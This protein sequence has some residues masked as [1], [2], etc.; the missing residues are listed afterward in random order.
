MKELTKI[1]VCL[2]LTEMD[3]K[4]ISY[5]FFLAQTY[6]TLQKIYFVHNIKFDFPE[7]AQDI[8][9]NLEQPLGEIISDDIL[10]KVDTH[11]KSLTQHIEYEVILTEDSSTPAALVKVANNHEIQLVITGRKISYQG[12]GQVAEKLL[13]TQNFNAD[14]LMVPETAFHQI[15]RI[16]VPTDFSKASKKAIEVG[17]TLQKLTSANLQCQHVFNIPTHY[18]PYIPVDNLVQKLNANAQKQWQ[19]FSKTLYQLGAEAMNCELIFS[20]RKNTAQAIYDHAIKQQQDL[21]VISAKGKGSITS[22]LIGSVAIRLIQMDMHIP[23][24][25]VR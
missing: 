3:D 25:V 12:S 16:S 23:L 10:E 1:M 22:F 6:E 4:L 13:R 19:T 17:V 21:I 5:S 18:F 8:F 14:L 7:V 2:D 15:T 11:A 24:L 20:E 9:N